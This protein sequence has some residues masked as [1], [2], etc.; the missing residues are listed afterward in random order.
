MKRLVLAAV[1]AGAPGLPASAEPT[2]LLLQPGSTVLGFRA[3]GLGGMIPV[4]GTFERFRG[5][6]ALDAGDPGFCRIEIEAETVSLAMPTQGM[7]E[8]ATGPDLLNVA[9]HPRFVYAGAC[10]AGAVEGNLTLGGVTRPFRAAIVREGGRF[11]ATGLMRRADWGMGA[12]PMMAGPE[13]RLR[14]TTGLPA[15]LR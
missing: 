3:Y 9:V 14:I 11:E 4:D 5:T 7:T 6:L 1:L 12:R 13:V 15:T 10:R 2:T 8:D